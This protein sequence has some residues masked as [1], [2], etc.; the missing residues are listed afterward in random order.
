MPR[1][2]TSPPP[3][4]PSVSST[5]CGPWPLAAFTQRTA[6]CAERASTW[7]VTGCRRVMAGAPPVDRRQRDTC[8][9]PLPLTSMPSSPSEKH[10]MLEPS[11]I[12]A[13]PAHAIPRG[14]G[15]RSQQVGPEA[16]RGRRAVRAA[17]GATCGHTMWVSST[18]PSSRSTSL[19]IPCS[20][21]VQNR[22]GCSD[23]TNVRMP[24][25]PPR[26]WAECKYGAL[27]EPRAAGP[28]AHGWR[29]HARARARQ[30][31]ACS[32]RARRPH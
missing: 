18:E 16:S 6:P 5:S 26:P 28:R 9:L 30:V 1:T 32:A 15:A 24:C 2:P 19:A 3:P 10:V 7:V 8:P 29:A 13:R 25:G 23:Q 12:C 4:T 17:A 20:L 14:T 22:R 27:R 11:C 21:P 31:R